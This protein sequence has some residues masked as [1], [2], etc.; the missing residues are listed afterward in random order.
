MRE[1]NQRSWGKLLFFFCQRFKRDREITARHLNF[2]LGMF[3]DFLL[4]FR[5]TPVTFYHIRVNRFL[6]YF[7][8]FCLTSQSSRFAG[9]T[10]TYL[11]S[12]RPS[13]IYNKLSPTEKLGNECK[14]MHVG[15]PFRFLAFHWACYCS[16]QKHFLDNVKLFIM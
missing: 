10:E 2:K 12:P 11:F 5:Q 16:T 4:S 9:C 3:F 1:G 13:Y 8:L 7:V 6:D 15:F 14:G